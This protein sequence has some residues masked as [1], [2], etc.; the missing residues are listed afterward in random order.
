MYKE[1]I[2]NRIFSIDLNPNHIGYTVCD[3]HGES[4]KIINSGVI[5]FKYLND[6]DNSLK[7]KGLFSSSKER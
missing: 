2:K 5:S 6:L 1:S 4:P 7:G 3:W